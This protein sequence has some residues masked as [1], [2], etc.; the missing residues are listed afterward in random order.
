MAAKTETE[1]SD[2]IVN[3]KRMNLDIVQPYN[4]TFWGTFTISKLIEEEKWINQ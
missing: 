3:E 4:C 1:Y 2:N